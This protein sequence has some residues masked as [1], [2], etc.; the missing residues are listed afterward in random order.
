MG[1]QHTRCDRKKHDKP[2]SLCIRE[3]KINETGRF[4]DDYCNWQRFAALENIMRWL[5]AIPAATQLMQ[6]ETLKVFHG[7]LLLKE[8][9]HKQ[10]N[11]MAPRR[12]LLFC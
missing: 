10:V 1:G 11:A 8:P 4:F 6:S 5:P 2:R 12:T 9:R 3:S 7:Q